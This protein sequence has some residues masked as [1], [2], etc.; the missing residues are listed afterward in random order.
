MIMYHRTYTCEKQQ[1]ENREILTLRELLNVR[2]NT[3]NDRT[4]TKSAPLTPEFFW[5]Q[6]KDHVF[7]SINVP[8]VKKDSLEINLTDDGRVHFKGAGGNVGHEDEYELD[9]TLFKG[10]KPSESKHIITARGIRFKIIKEES[11]P[12]WDRLL[13]QSGRNVHCKIDWDHWKDED[14]DEE[15]HSFTDSNFGDNKDLQDMDFV[16]GGGSSDEEDD[17]AEPQL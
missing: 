6:R 14:E 13:K 15:E 3:S 7:L 11:G 4:T 10:I 1:S 16:S 5:A 9:I 2:A 8:N 12:Y 17:N